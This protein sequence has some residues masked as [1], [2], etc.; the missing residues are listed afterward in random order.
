MPSQH[1]YCGNVWNS[2][3]ACDLQSSDKKVY[4]SNPPSPKVENFQTKI[5]YHAGDQTPDLLPL[6]QQ[7]KEEAIYNILIEFGIPRNLV[8][9]IKMCLSKTYSR[10]AYLKNIANPMIRHYWLSLE[11]SVKIKRKLIFSIF[12]RCNTKITL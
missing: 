7:V 3:Q 4:I 12:L 6:V 2:I 9:L 5:Y 10:I 11:N 1:T 8:K